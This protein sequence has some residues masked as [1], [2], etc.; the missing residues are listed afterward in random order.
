MSG[1][2]AFEPFDT[3]PEVI[4]ITPRHFVDVR[5]WFFESYHRDD[6]AAAGIV[7]EFR[8]DAHSRSNVGVLRGLHFQ[9]APHEQGKLVRCATGRV[10]DVAVDIRQS[11]TT[12][13]RWVSTI[14]SAEDHS[15]IW[16]PTGFAHG[17]LALDGPADVLYKLTQEYAPA[18]A[19]VIRWDDPELAIDWPA[20]RPTLSPSDAAAPLLRSLTA[21]RE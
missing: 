14:L 21:R 10:F 13:G 11:S 4:R 8:Q 20:S 2:F 5:G 9:L 12:F 1:K 18:H 19:R 17:T 7:A 16:I 3:L 15:M 6:F